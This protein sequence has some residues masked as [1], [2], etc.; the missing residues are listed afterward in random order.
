MGRLLNYE[1][2]TIRDLTAN[3]DAAEFDPYIVEAEEVDIKLILGNVL[4]TDLVNNLTS[5]DPNYVFLLDGGSYADGS[6]TYEIKGLRYALEYYALARYMENPYIHTQT[7]FTNHSDEFGTKP[8]K[9]ELDK[10]AN[11]VRSVA[12]SVMDDIKKYLNA[13]NSDFPLWNCDSQGN[14]SGSVKLSIL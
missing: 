12:W 7:G 3:L 11:N 14:R 13:K 9:S 10:L 1:D 4:F 5:S 6:Y 8:T 2:I